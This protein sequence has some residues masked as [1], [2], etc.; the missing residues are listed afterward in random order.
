MQT[1]TRPKAPADGALRAAIPNHIWGSPCVANQW[2]PRMKLLSPTRGL[3]L[4]GPHSDP[5]LTLLE[6]ARDGLRCAAAGAAFRA[7]MTP[8]KP[9]HNHLRARAADAF[10]SSATRC[11]RH[12][13]AARYTV[14]TDAG[15]SL[16]QPPTRAYTYE[17]LLS[18]TK[19]NR[20][21]AP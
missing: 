5:I 3:T 15:V 4:L 13:A 10:N 18:D 12:E 17:S 8:R 21:L 1:R 9:Q 16:C 20:S 7:V 6:G 2:N 19:S 14:H 11:P